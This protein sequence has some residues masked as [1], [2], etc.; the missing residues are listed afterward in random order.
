MGVCLAE[1]A[2]TIR[3]FALI[4][5]KNSVFMQVVR[6]RSKK[7]QGKGK[8]C[9]NGM[10]LFFRFIFTTLFLLERSQAEHMLKNDCFFFFYQVSFWRS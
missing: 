5:L 8:S 7:P 10:Y 6:M 9:F 4:T 2:M 3:K 1:D